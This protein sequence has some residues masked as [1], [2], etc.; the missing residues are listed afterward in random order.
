ML[1]LKRGYNMLKT[2]IF[3][4]VFSITFYSNLQL[5]SIISPALAKVEM[6]QPPYA[7]WGRIAMERTKEKYPEASIVDYLHV[8]RIEGQK[9]TTE[10][11]K[12]WLKEK[13]REFGVFVNIEF[14]TNTERIVN[15]TFKEVTQ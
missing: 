10:R 11:F 1:L 4:L 13:N 2:V 14:E 6:N 12:L 8:E 15:V 7:K 3:V 9:T 5:P